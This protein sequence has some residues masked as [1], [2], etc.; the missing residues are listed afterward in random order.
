[1]NTI[2]KLLNT[3]GTST[4][5]EILAAKKNI[6]S[7]APSE[8]IA[9]LAGARLINMSELDKN[10]QIRSGTFKSLIGNDTIAARFL[11]ENSFE[12]RPDFKMI[13][14]TNHLPTCNDPAIFKS[15]RII[16]IPFQ[17]NFTEA[18]QDTN[19]KEDFERP[20]VLSEVANWLIQGY[21]YYKTGKFHYIPDEVKDA[22]NIYHQELDQLECYIEECLQADPN[23]EVPLKKLHSHYQDWCIENRYPRDTLKE[24]KVSM[25]HHAKISKKRPNGTPQNTTQLQM[26]I[27]YTFQKQMIA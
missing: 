22:T 10:T 12:F 14:S 7:S 26:V 1:M 13:L 4:S 24:F 21:R 17:N 25:L 8:D 2:M 20:K 6:N 15:N 3:Y 18:K 9:R 5:A 11:H 19:L 23:G 27:G 16:L